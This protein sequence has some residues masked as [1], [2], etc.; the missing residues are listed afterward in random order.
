MRLHVCFLAISAQRNNL[1]FF[2]SKTHFIESAP[3]K[4]SLAVQNKCVQV[5][6]MIKIWKCKK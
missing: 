4:L 3:E 5:K 1:I 2:S 6:T